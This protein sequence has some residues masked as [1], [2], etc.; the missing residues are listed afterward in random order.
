MMKYEEPNMQIILLDQLDVV[1]ASTL[2][3]EEYDK[4]DT[5][6]WSDWY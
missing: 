3:S 4:V 6:N 1:T 5:G 2:T